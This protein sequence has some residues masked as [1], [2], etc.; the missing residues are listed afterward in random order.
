MAR[1][2]EGLGARSSAR[3]KGFTSDAPHRSIPASGLVREA[4]RDVALELPTWQR[5]VPEAPP[6]PEVAP[7]PAPSTFSEAA[8][9]VGSGDAEGAGACSLSSELQTQQRPPVA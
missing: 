2:E 1:G 6:A 8:R 7:P 9:R 4:W 3:G 5:R